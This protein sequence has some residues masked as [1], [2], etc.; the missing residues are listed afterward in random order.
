MKG[1][2][3]QKLIWNTSKK[4]ERKVQQ[5]QKNQLWFETILEEPTMSK[6]NTST[7]ELHIIIKNIQQ[8]SWSATAKRIV[9]AAPQDHGFA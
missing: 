9:S 8:L 2:K 4:S 6:E 1:N 5:M 7:I 3:T